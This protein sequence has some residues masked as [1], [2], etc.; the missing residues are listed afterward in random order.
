MDTVA[1]DV[2]P[3]QQGWS[4]GLWRS[5]IPFQ[6]APITPRGLD[7]PTESRFTTPGP[8]A[9]CSQ[10]SDS[11]ENPALP[12]ERPQTAQWPRTVTCYGPCC[13]CPPPLQLLTCWFSK[14]AYCDVLGGVLRPSALG[15]ACS[16]PAARR[17]SPPTH[18]MP[19]IRAP[20]AH[21]PATRS[22]WAPIYCD[23]KNRTG[24]FCGGTTPL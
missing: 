11:I 20:M 16:P 3:C 7:W 18:V 13:S 21:L 23:N 15:E 24:R 8:P 10:G 9:S 4:G 12:D 5:S 6:A 2:E 19:P 1:A 17:C 14:S 22:A